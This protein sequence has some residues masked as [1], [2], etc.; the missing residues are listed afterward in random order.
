MKRH[1]ILMVISMIATSFCSGA[2]A[3]DGQF[4]FTVGGVP[5]G[6]TLNVRSKPRATSSIV[7]KLRNGDSGFLDVNC[8]NAR[9]GKKITVDSPD[10][11][12]TGIWCFVMAGDDGDLTGWINTKYAR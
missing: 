6:D 8:R 11:F 7:G 1:S 4:V 3:A 2:I 10:R 5:A 9:S 12:A